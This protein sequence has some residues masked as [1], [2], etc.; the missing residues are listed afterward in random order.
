MTNKDYYYVTGNTAEGLVNFLNSNVKGLEKIIIIKHPSHTLK[1]IILKNVISNFEEECNLEIF[2]S[3]LGNRFIEGVIL[4]EK[5]I[6][7]ISDTI[8]TSDLN[9]VEIDLTLFLENKLTVNDEYEQAKENFHLLTQQAY[10]DFSKGLKIHDDLETIF[11]NEMDFNKADLLTVEFIKEQLENKPKKARTPHVYHRL[12]GTNTADGIVNI[13][14]HII[15][16]ITYVYHIKGRAGTGKSTFMKKVLAASLEYGYDVELFHC[17]FDPKSIDMVLVRDLN[18]CIFDSTNP[19]EFFPKRNG[20]S[21]IDLYEETVTPGT[22]E[23][24]AK[25][26]KEVNSHYKMYMKKGIQH[27]KMAGKCLADTDQDYIYRQK[28]IEGINEFILDKV[29]LD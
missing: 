23:K 4:R 17:S 13:V 16:R 8:A 21:I 20:E 12:F 29:V 7:I 1:T 6:A 26:I 10:Q 3:A 14:P 18:F 15:E 19:H 2:Q 22:D 11:I 9:A 27:L 5:S 28:E 24:F 25:R